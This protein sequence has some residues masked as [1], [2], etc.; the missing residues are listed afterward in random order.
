[1]QTSGLR[2]V[3]YALL[4][5]VVVGTVIMLADNF[6]PF[7]PI[8][9]IS[10]PSAAARA[11]KT[12]W[13]KGGENLIVTSTDSPT[14]VADNYMM[15]VQLM[16]G[17]S[18]TPGLGKF[19]HIVHRGSNPCSG[20]SSSTS[21]STGQ[22]GIQLADIPDADPQYKATG[23]PELM[24]PGLFLDKYKNDLHVFVHTINADVGLFLESVT[25]EDL[26]LSQPLTIGIACTGKT[27]EVYVNCRLYSTKLLTGKPVLP[28]AENQWF[29]RF[30]AFP[31]SGIVKSL[32]LWPSSLGATDYMAMCH[33]ASFDKNDLPDT[34]PTAS[35]NPGTK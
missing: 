35:T 27:L 29:G 25:I 26:P 22:S 33:P 9:P 10:G 16:I 6:Y 23:L 34:C 24:N 11:G 14:K 31:M 30:C 8:N 12:F 20:V 15:S 2:Y 4:V 7:L 3:I 21:G 1:M 28:P 17:D 19:R 13:P 5:A 32:T 18:R